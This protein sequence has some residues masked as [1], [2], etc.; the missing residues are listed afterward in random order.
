MC[1]AL[2]LTYVV[3]FLDVVLAYIYTNTDSDELMIPPV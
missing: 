2:T 1:G 3:H